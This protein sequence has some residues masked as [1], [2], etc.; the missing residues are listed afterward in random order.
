MELTKITKYNQNI[1]SES[2]LFTYT[3]GGAELKEVMVRINLGDV[4][5]P[6][7]GGGQYVLKLS[8]NGALIAPD[9]TVQVATG[10]T[11]AVLVSRSIPIATDDVLSLRMIGLPGDTSVNAE[12]SIRDQTPLR[13][14]ELAGTGVVP[15][16][17]DYGGTDALTVMTRDRQRIDN[18]TVAV[19]RRT[20]Y[21][22]GRR[23]PQYVVGQTPTDVN[24]HWAV[25]VM[26]D[27]GDYTVFVY[28]QGVIQAA[29]QNLTVS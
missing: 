23:G 20:D 24:G 25:P 22:A 3:Y 21:D 15:V 10:A 8:I 11:R 7:V 26:L 1:S 6:I 17:H 12:I 9:A 2:E 29:A 4:S 16:D 28:K 27:P 5:K 13:A 19:Y 18:A 14:E